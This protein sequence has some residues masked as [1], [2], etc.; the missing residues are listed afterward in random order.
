MMVK[1]AVYN[2][3][4]SNSMFNC[5]FKAANLLRRDDIS[6]TTIPSPTAKQGR[7]GAYR[8]FFWKIYAV[9]MDAAAYAQQF[10]IQLFRLKRFY[11]RLQLR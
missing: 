2:K 8:R 1:Q 7:G 10:I 4:L 9:H 6:P 5:V 3:S 11:K